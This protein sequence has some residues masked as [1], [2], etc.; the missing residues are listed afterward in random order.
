M[1]DSGA[2][3]G[4]F[5]PVREGLRRGQRKPQDVG[6]ELLKLCTGRCEKDQKIWAFV[7]VMFSVHV[8][9]EK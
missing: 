9:S 6:P 4:E 8:G 3:R 5:G 1:L 7:G 2:A